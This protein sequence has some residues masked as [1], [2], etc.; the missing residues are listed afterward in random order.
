MTHNLQFEFRGTQAGGSHFSVEMRGMLPANTLFL[1]GLTIFV[2]Q[3]WQLTVVFFRSAGSVHPV[4]WMLSVVVFLHY[5]AQTLHTVHLWRYRSNGAGIKALEV[6][7]EILFMMS[8]V[9]QTSLLILI[10]L[11]YTLLQSC[12]GELD[13]MIPVCFMVAI[14]HVMLV[15]FGKI[16][17]DASYKF[18]ENEGI[19]GWVLLLMRLLLYLWFLWAVQ[20]SARVGGARLQTF[21]R[22][23]CIAGSMYF[24]AYPA[25]FLITQC[26][27][28][29]WQHGVMSVGLT[30]MQAA[31]S[32][33]LSRLFLTRGEYFR[34][35]TLSASELPGGC[36]IG[37]VKEE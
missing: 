13:L 17:D 11:G 3:F 1:C 8:Q 28:P 23:F 6:I 19:L 5:L 34:V 2:W 10:G 21:L 20:S 31:S 4:I 24:L 37:M 36:K 33:W 35:S 25:V 29:Y 32:F 26:F 7:S 30:A 12:L 16:K 27:A 18:H 22:Q 15:G 9:T 14:V